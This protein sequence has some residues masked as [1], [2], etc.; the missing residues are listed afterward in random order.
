MDE[1]SAIIQALSTTKG[2]YKANRLMFGVTVAP[3]VWQQRITMILQGLNGVKVFYDDIIVEG[4]NMEEHAERLREVL[5][6]LA[7][8]NLRVNWK[9]CK[10][11]QDTVEYLGHKISSAGIS[12]CPDKTAAVSDAPRPE[13]VTEL[14]SWLGLVNY[15]GKFIKDL[16]TKMAPLY[17]LLSK[18]TR[19]KWS[20]EAETAFQQIKS[21]VMS[22]TTLMA[23][24]DTLP[25][26]LATDASSIGLGAVLSHRL[27][28]GTERPIYFASRML[29]KAEQHY[30]QID[31]EATAIFWAVNK[32]YRYCYGRR[33]TLITDHKPLVTIF[34]RKENCPT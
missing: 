34:G 26:L 2:V 4:K 10:F 11:F 23:Y 8:N 30:S 6:R 17:K 31:K 28:D 22:D 20:K 32:F 24:D 21:E 7:E 19:F 25:L 13:N 9:K 16:A 5:R 33:F 14:R 18:D 15:Y 27:P 29:S 12:R 3:A 1:E